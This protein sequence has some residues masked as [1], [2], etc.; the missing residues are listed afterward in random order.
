[1]RHCTSIL[2]LLGLLAGI[3]GYSLDDNMKA[4]AQASLKKGAQY[5]MNVQNEDGSWGRHKHPAIA[6]LCIMA[7]HNAPVDEAKR[8]ACIDKGMEF[9]MSFVQPDGSIYPADIHKDNPTK[10]A[11]YPNYTTSV[12][13]LCLATLDREQDRPRMIK[14]RKYL[15][16]TQFKDKSMIDYG[17]IGYGKTQRADLSNAAWATEALYYTEY[18]DKEPYTKDP[19]AK[20]RTAEM[21]DAMAEFVAKTQNI[22]EVNKEPYVSTHPWDFGGSIYR[23]NESKAGSYEVAGVTKLVSSSSMTYAALKTLLYARVDRDDPRVKGA[24]KFLMNHYE[25][26]ENPGM[27]LQGLYYYLHVMARTLDAWG[28]DILTDSNGIKHNWREE[29][30]NK[31]A[32]MQNEDG[33]WTN[34]HGR[35][36]ESDP[37]LATPY[38]VIALKIVIGQGDLKYK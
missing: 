4:K 3:C 36:F 22:P 12:V 25:L 37:T 27:G 24:M 9:V 13:L 7:V 29:I 15:M 17:G 30:I 23:P 2:I 33:S 6:A 28:H 20:K 16:S 35:F 18:L 34:K 38:S 26:D 10:S 8:K 21:W 32:G 31:F 5:L 11:F 1:M 19:E 14:A